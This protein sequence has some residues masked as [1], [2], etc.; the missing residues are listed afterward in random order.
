MQI[1]AVRFGRMEVDGV[2]YHRD[3]IIMLS[4][5]L[6]PWIRDQGHQLGTQDLQTVLDTPPRLLII[7][8][9][10]VGRMRV[11][12][13]LVEYLDA[14][15]ITCRVMRTREAAAAFNTAVREGLHCAGAF[16]I[17]C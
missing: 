11:D 9:G 14:Q 16:H 17:T 5:I 6:C 1:T 13:G 2:A 10:M 12:R 8:T 4:G 15:N 7:G 3:L